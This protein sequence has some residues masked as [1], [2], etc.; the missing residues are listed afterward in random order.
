MYRNIEWNNVDG[1]WTAYEVDGDS[2]K[3]TGEAMRGETNSVIKKLFL[4]NTYFRY[5][6]SQDT[7]EAITKLR[8]ENDISYG[9]LDLKYDL[10]QDNS[11]LEDVTTEI[12]SDGSKKTY[13]LKDVSGKVMFNHDSLNA[14]SMLENTHTVDADYIYRDFKE[15]EL[16]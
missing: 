11:A 7:A 14:F 15:L 2:M 12:E 4:Y 13:S 16:N 8:K 6:G 10:S 9:A 5:D 1:I 3:Q